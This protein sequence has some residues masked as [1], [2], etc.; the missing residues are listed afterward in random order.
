MNETRGSTWSLLKRLVAAIVILI[1]TIAFFANAAGLGGIWIVRRPAQDSVTALSTLVNDKLGVIDQGLTRIGTQ[2]EESRLALIQVN[3]LANQLGDRLEE[4][5]PRVTELIRSAGDDLAPKIADAR[6][7][8]AQLHDAAVSINAVLETIDRLGFV[9]VPT[10]GDEL[11]TVS[12]R[13]DAAQA[14]VQELRD[15]ID[16]ARAGAAA[17]LIAAVVTRTTRINDALTQIKSSTIKYQAAVAHK[18]Q[19][20]TK[21]SQRLSLAI[22]LLVLLLTAFFLTVAA[23]QLLLIYL[24]WQ[25]LRR[26]SLS[27]LRIAPVSFGTT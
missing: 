26:G 16:Q 15:A 1:A 14:K 10:F 4:A 23:G 2:V 12:Q 17:N 6:V 7:K 21:L 5:S 24:C 13:I 19:Q 25:Y 27:S 9:N 20:V 22:T 8:A 18:R 3:N 11:S